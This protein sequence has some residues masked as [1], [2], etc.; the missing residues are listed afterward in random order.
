MFGISFLAVIFVIAI[1]FYLANHITRPLINLVSATNEV[2]EGNLDIQV[3]TTSND[4]IAEL[5]QTFNLMT[6][7]LNISR[8]ELFNAYNE[9][10]ISWTKAMHL[11]DEE[12]EGH[13][14][15]VVELSIAFGKSLGI[16]GNDLV[17]LYRGCFNA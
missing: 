1:G 6:N 15:R 3:K 2:A 16:T 8:K 5:T 7:N 17:N 13:M 14:N 12:T 11:R 10:L 9:T 4:E